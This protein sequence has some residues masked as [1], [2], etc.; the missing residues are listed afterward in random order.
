[1]SAQD[2][3]AV[4]SNPGA[5]RKGLDPRR[6]P[7]G[8]DAK[9]RNVRRKLAKLDGP[10]METLAAMFKSEDPGERIEA[11]KFWG[12]YRLPVPSE[13][14]AVDVNLRGVGLSPTIA[15]RLAALESH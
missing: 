10:A 3:D 9:T 1:M 6:Q 5:F 2:C 14:T 13:K 12:R 8:L 4:P 7:G 15:A 11:L